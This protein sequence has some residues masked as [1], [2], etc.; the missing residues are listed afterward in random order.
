M[1]NNI[2]ITGGSNG[3][4]KA[5][6]FAISPWADNIYNL[7]VVPPI[8]GL[9]ENVTTINCDVSDLRSM[10]K[11]ISKFNLATYVNIL[12]NCAGINSQDYLEDVQLSSWDAVMDVN[13]KAHLITAKFFLEDLIKTKG[14]ILNII[15]NASHMPMTG[16]AVYNASKGAAHILTLQMARELTKRHGITVFGISP[17]KLHGTNM[18]QVIEESV[19]RVRGWTPEEAEKYQQGSL[20]SGE[21]EPEDLAEFISWILIHGHRHQHFTGCVIPYGA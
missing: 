6:I 2:V 8:F 9:P 15:S 10:D 3:L 7:D 19:C 21:I 13:A 11:A 5:I 1:K 18:S 14:T 12:I 20:L 17:A 16:S 4:G